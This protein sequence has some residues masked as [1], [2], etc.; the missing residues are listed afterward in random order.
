MRRFLP[1]HDVEPL[2]A[3][4]P[5]VPYDGGLAWFGCGFGEGRA[6]FELRDHGWK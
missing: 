2:R 5:L 4:V 6:C 1:M 3:L